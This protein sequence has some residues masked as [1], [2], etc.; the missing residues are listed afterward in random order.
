MATCASCMRALPLEQFVNR[1]LSNVKA[2]RPATC[3]SCATA[4][5]RPDPELLKAKE[6]AC[7]FYDESRGQVDGMKRKVKNSS[8]S[9]AA[10][11][12]AKKDMD[13]GRLIYSKFEEHCKLEDM[14]L[15]LCIK[16][17]LLKLNAELATHKE[18]TSTDQQLEAPAM[19]TAARL[20]AAIAAV[21]AEQQRVNAMYALTFCEEQALTGPAVTDFIST[22]RGTQHG[23]RVPLQV[24]A[25]NPLLVC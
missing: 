15:D 22:L 19:R 5:T 4:R 1:Q 12:P 21:S 16:Q 9:L 10:E 6:V 2:G 18:L 24:Y 23:A 3:T 20:N 7:H 25:T 13:K 17:E 14:N 11:K 8:V